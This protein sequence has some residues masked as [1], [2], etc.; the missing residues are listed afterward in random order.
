MLFA[1]QKIVFIYYTLGLNGGEMF[2][3]V[4]SDTV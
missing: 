3:V 1:Y 4:S 2:D